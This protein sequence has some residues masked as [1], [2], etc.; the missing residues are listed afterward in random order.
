MIRSAVEHTICRGLRCSQQV[1]IAL[2]AAVEK[3]FLGKGIPFLSL[4]KKSEAGQHIL[5]LQTQTE[6]Y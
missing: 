3:R 1:K 6:L 2:I 4:S 5:R